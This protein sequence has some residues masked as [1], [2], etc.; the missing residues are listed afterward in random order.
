[1]S[2]DFAVPFR[3]WAP[4]VREGTQSCETVVQKSNRAARSRP[5]QF[6]RCQESGRRATRADGAER[7][8]EPD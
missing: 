2:A 3:E 1:V 6:E 5:V 4:E 8:A 7:R